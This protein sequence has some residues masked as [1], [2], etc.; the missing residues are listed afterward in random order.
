M[1]ECFNKYDISSTIQH[2]FMISRVHTDRRDGE[3]LWNSV[4]N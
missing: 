1:E 2:P 4:E 3:V